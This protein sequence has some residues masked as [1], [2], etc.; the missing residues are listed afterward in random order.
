MDDNSGGKLIGEPEP[1]IF[2]PW[3]AEIQTPFISTDRP[4]A[5]TSVVQCITLFDSFLIVTG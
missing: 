2:V 1:I 4:P 5:P 3:Y